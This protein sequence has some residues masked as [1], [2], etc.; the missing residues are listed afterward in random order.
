MFNFSKTDYQGI[1]LPIATTINMII[2]AVR[3]GDRIAQLI[4]ERIATP[5]VIEVD[6]L[7]STLRGSGGYGSTGTN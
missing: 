6:E 2:A 4:L 7:E 3:Q 5:P 1:T